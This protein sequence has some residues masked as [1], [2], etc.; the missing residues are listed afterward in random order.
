MTPRLSMSYSAGKT[1]IAAACPVAV[2]PKYVATMFSL[3]P[4]DIAIAQQTRRVYLAYRTATSSAFKKDT[5]TI[6]A[7]VAPA[8]LTCDLLLAKSVTS[9]VAAIPV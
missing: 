8:P 6:D 4:S 9:S 5:T 1:T 3:L 7:V 2:G